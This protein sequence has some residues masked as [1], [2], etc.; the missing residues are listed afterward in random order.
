MEELSA[1]ARTEEKDEADTPSTVSS[2]KSSST[3]TVQQ[4]LSIVV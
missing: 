3:A 1:P 2:A 4:S